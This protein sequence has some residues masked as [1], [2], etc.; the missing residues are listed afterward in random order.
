MDE[1]APLSLEFRTVQKNK[2]RRAGIAFVALGVPIT[3][4][5]VFGFVRGAEM[6]GIWGLGVGIA[7]TVLGAIVLMRVAKQR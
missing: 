4:V 1:P 5:G 6:L 2:K 7:L 3:A